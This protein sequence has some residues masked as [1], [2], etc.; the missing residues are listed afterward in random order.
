MQMIRSER[1]HHRTDLRGA[2]QP[3]TA[4]L[5]SGTPGSYKTPFDIG[6]HCSVRAPTVV[7]RGREYSC[8][9]RREHFSVLNNDRRSPCLEKRFSVA[10]VVAVAVCVY[11][12]FRMYVV[13]RDVEAQYLFS[14]SGYSADF[15]IN[16]SSQICE[17][18]IYWKLL[19][20]T[21]FVCPQI[22]NWH[23]WFDWYKMVELLFTSKTIQMK[24]IHSVFFFSLEN[25]K[26]LELLYYC[27]C[28][29]EGNNFSLDRDHILLYQEK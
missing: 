12:W 23:A 29:Y 5:V 13:L 28:W 9:K 1:T 14:C 2:H 10:E 27:S 11:F 21:L 20:Q 25:D 26:L 7:Y 19:C 8:Y 16:I 24:Q 17:R 18:D 6:P 22:F 4:D 3:W 15:T